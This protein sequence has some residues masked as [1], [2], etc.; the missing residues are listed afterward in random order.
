M[1]TII[2][3]GPVMMDAVASSLETVAIVWLGGEVLSPAL[4]VHRVVGALIVGVLARF[5]FTGILAN[6]AP[7]HNGDD[8]EEDPKPRKP[9]Q[10]PP[11]DPP[12]AAA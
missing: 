9:V 8:A 7:H 12:E 1:A 4:G 5:I 10:E 11:Q 6:L 2:H 3:V